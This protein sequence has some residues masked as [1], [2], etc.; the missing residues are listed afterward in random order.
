[1]PFPYFSSLLYNVREHKIYFKGKG[2]D[3][4]STGKLTLENA[5]SVEHRNAYRRREERE[6]RYFIER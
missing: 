3:R 4:I 2:A 5:E 6:V 1:M